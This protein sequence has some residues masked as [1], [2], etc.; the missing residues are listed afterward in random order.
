MQ[1]RRA[2]SYRRPVSAFVAFVAF[3]A[4]G[5]SD[6]DAGAPTATT[7]SVPSPTDS[8]VRASG[9][10]SEASAS[11]SEAVSST[12]VPATV[13]TETIATVPEQGVPGLD[14]ADPFCR[15]WSEFAGSFQALAFASAAGS[16]PVA[17]ARLEVVASGAVSAAAQTLAD[18]FPEPIAFER[19]LFVDDVI[20]PFA[21]RVGR[22]SDELRAAGLSPD[23]IAQLGDVWL[24]ALVDAGVDEPAVAV[25]VPDELAGAVDVA[26]ASFSADAPPIVADPSL[27]TD[28]EAPA[29]L[30]HIA[31]NCP[32]QGILG[33]NDAID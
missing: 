13:S 9:Q 14:S 6:G 15:A 30:E 18:E 19:D 8:S 17:A 5:C 32:D 27:V 29:T 10:A 24:R 28:A 11:S 1:G 26:A 2:S 3:V 25:A 12:E 4:V 23:Q 31:E 20:G 21:R 7:A 22:A 33:G 16:D